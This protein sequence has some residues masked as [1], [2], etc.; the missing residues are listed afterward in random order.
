MY[1]SSDWRG[2]EI[3]VCLLDPISNNPNLLQTDTMVQSLYRRW[4]IDRPKCKN[5]APPWFIHPPTY[6]RQGLPKICFLIKVLLDDFLWFSDMLNVKDLLFRSVNLLVERISYTFFDL[7]P[8]KISN[9]F[10]LVWTKS[11][12]FNAEC[13]HI[14]F[15]EVLAFWITFLA[16]FS[17]SPDFFHLE[18]LLFFLSW[19]L[20]FP[21]PT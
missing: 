19:P 6:T 4:L 17:S 15:L 21:K 2:V 1:T 16:V 13:G 11:L 8:S 9:K 12:K 10:K 18:S 14:L 7:E 20:V 3:L 5:I